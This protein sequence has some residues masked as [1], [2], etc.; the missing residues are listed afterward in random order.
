M[1]TAWQR[2][3]SLHISLIDDILEGNFWLTSGLILSFKTS[4]EVRRQIHKTEEPT[5][6]YK[7]QC[8]LCKSHP[9]KRKKTKD[10]GPIIVIYS[11]TMIC[12]SAVPI[13][14]SAI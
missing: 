5:C 13:S 2:I 11:Y 3:I 6:Y 12:T 14:C 7:Q 8:A 1:T 10:H 4:M 9:K